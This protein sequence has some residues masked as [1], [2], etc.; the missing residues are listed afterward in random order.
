ML[1]GKYT[2]VATDGVAATQAGTQVSQ[3]ETPGSRPQ[4]LT[5]ALNQAIQAELTLN[6]DCKA[7]GVTIT[8]NGVEPSAAP[9]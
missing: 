5:A 6:A 4:A 9:S 7:I 3:Y 1:H 2:I 8:V